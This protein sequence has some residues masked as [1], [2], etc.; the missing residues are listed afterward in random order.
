MSTNVVATL[1]YGVSAEIA[2]RLI[3]D[4]NFDGEALYEIVSELNLEY[5]EVSFFG[6]YRYQSLD[7]ME[8]AVFVKSSMQTFYD[9]AV[10]LLPDRSTPEITDEILAELD[11]VREYLDFDDAHEFGWLLGRSLA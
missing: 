1:G 7:E 6:D 4:V 9:V 5:V 2:D 8:W 10:E 11:T 3:N